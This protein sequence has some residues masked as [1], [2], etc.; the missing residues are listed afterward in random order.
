MSC[1]PPSFPPL[2]LSVREKESRGRI[3]QVT[4]KCTVCHLH[5]TIVSIHPCTMADSLCPCIALVD[6]IDGSF[7]L[8]RG[9]NHSSLQQSC[10][11]RYSWLLAGIP[12]PCC[13]ATSKASLYILFIQQCCYCIYSW[14]SQ[15][16][17]LP[18]MPNSCGALTH[19]SNVPE[20]SNACPT[21]LVYW[22]ITDQCSEHPCKCIVW[23]GFCSKQF[24]QFGA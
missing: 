20:H 2:P 21:S 8:G 15:S 10:L 19:S 22:E 4:T 24:S 23:F 9:G 7:I 14:S 16:D 18:L 1:L 12:L 6:C 13:W 3:R 11:F 17:A 5:I